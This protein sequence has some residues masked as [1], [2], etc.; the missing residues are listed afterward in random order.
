MVKYWEKWPREG[1]GRAEWTVEDWSCR[2]NF[3]E[4]LFF[5]LQCIFSPL[6]GHV[7]WTYTTRVGR[8]IYVYGGVK[9]CLNYSS[10]QCMELVRSFQKTFSPNLFSFWPNLRR[11]RSTHSTNLHHGLQMQTR[12]CL[13][14][15]DRPFSYIMRLLFLF[16]S[17][18]WSAA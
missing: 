14:D 2:S 8:W 3:S 13:T 9:V 12:K 4:P 18:L 17:G 7:S 15:D 5:L 11:C 1:K 10:Q 6:R 16:C